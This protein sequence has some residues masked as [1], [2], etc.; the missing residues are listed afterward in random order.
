MVLDDLPQECIRERYIRGEIRQMLDNVIL[1][2]KWHLHCVLKR[3]ENRHKRARLHQG[4]GQ[5]DSDG[6]LRVSG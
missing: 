4:G 5:S 3:I 6:G 2:G 1:M